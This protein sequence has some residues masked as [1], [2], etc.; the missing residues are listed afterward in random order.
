VLGPAVD[1][2]HPVRHRIR[3]EVMV[4]ATHG[5]RSGRRSR[6]D[7]GAQVFSLLLRLP[8]ARALGV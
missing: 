5:K 4:Y 3:K 2:G 7:P 1:R 6:R 8:G